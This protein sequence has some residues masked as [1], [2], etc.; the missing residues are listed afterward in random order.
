[1]WLP[2]RHSGKNCFFALSQA[3]SSSALCSLANPSTAA[4]ETSTVR[5]NHCRDSFTYLID[6]FAFTRS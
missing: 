3:P 5:A 4:L 2:F 1:M 6:A